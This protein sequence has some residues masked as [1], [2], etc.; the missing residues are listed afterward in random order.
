MRI[1]MLVV[2][3]AA[4]ASALAVAV[5][6]DDPKPFISVPKTWDAAVEEAKKL[7]VPIVVHSHGWN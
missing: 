4:L 6:K 2:A 7:N 1:A 5:A 3:S